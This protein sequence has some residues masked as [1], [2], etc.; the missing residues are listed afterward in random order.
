L[1]IKNFGQNSI[2]GE[3]TV[4]NKKVVFLSV[5]FDPGWTAKVDGK[6]AKV[7]LTNIGFSGLFL[8]P[9]KHQIELSFLPRFYKTGSLFSFIGIIIFLILGILKYFLHT[10]NLNAQKAS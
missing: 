8:D 10:K 4:R 6:P 3:V 7:L 9:G 5:P 2:S 1:A